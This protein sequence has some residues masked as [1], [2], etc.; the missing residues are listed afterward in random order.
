MICAVVYFQRPFSR[1][2]DGTGY[3]I[4]VRRTDQDIMLGAFFEDTSYLPANTCI[5]VSLTDKA[6]KA[7]TVWMWLHTLYGDK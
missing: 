2:G 4:T 7:K 5:K 3:K 1:Q 6:G